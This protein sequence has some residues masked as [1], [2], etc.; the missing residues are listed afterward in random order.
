MSPVGRVAALARPVWAWLC[1]ALAAS[2]AAL[3]TNVAL[4]AVAPYA[5]SRSAV[6]T[7]FA[8][9]AVAVTA[10]RAL[11]AARA[12]LR[13]LERSCSHLAALRVLTRLRVGVYRALEPLAPSRV[14]GLRGGDVMA[15][16]VADVETLDG[17]FVRGLLPPAAA[18]LSGLVACVILGALDRR[19]G[20][21]L[22]A[23]LAAAGVWL[24][25]AAGRR[26]RRPAA[27]LAA[28]RGE[29]HAVVTEQ[30]DGLA[31]LVAYG[32]EARA[33]EDVRAR[34]AELGRA[35]H[36]LASVRGRS[37]GAGALLAGI[38]ALALLALAIPLVH[39][40]LVPGV[41]L[42]AVPLVGLA[43]FEGV[44][45]LGEAF[46]Q[47]QLGRAAAARTFELADLEPAVTDPPRPAP[48]PRLPDVELEAVRFRYDPGGPPVLDGAGFA[49]P[50]GGRLGLAGPSGA[51][52][53]TVVGLLLR[54]WDAGAGRVLLAGR[55]IRTYRG[56]DVRARFGVVPQRIHVFNG[57]LRDN[58]LLAD[59]DADDGRMLDACEQAQLGEFVWSLP[60]GLD[61]LVGE[62][63]M[64]LSGGERQRLAL[65][66]VFLRGASIVV[67]DEATA[68]LDA[69]T[70]R[71][72]LRAVDA[73][74]VGR[75][76]LV[77][78]HR[79]AALELAGRVIVLPAAPQSPAASR[80]RSSVAT[81]FARRS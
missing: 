27:R 49:L 65:A 67:L 77:I 21:A 79:P 53:T 29:V 31:D 32:H 23:F 76:L 45:S 3:A 30:V 19:L 22:L 50:A 41:A 7:G 37:A 81:S 24:P 26:S 72:V 46:R 10:V 9:I 11:A 59:G 40:G 17:F 56:A 73:F 74:A 52:K 16:I 57:T 33:V 2:A 35:R 38:A 6:V 68:H 66:R 12:A 70:E 4:M 28:V 58:L 69:A 64:K 55:D 15:R 51:G 20:L 61:T 42:A 47:V 43:A 39:G 44:Q 5:I 62:D 54:F 78:S 36:R 8:D 13:Y 14:D 75:S 34:S 63:G 71:R 25:L 60:D 18:G 48:L 80:P 1:L